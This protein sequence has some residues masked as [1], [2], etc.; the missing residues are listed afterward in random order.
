MRRSCS[1]AL[2]AVVGRAVLLAGCC[3][4]ASSARL[5]GPCE[6]ADAA[7]VE[8]PIIGATD[9][10]V[11]QLARN[12]LADLEDFW[13]EQFPDVFGEDFPPLQ[14]GYFSVDPGNVDPAAYPAASAAGPPVAG[15]REQRLL[16]HRA[17]RPELRLDQLRPRLPGRRSAHELRPVHPGA[18]DGARVR[19]RRAGAGWAAPSAVDRRRDPGRL[20]RRQPGPGGSPTGEAEHSTLRDPGA[21]R[22]AAR[23]PA[24]ARPGRH[25]RGRGAGAR[26]LLRPGRRPS[27][28]ASTAARRPAATT[29]APTGSSPQAAFDR[30]GRSTTRRQRR[31]RR[32]ARR[33]STTSLPG[34]WGQAFDELSGE[35]FDPP[36][37]RAVRRGAPRTVRRRQDLDL[38]Y[39]ADEN[40][41]GFDESDLAPAGLRGARRLRR[42]HRGR[43]ALRAGRPR[44]A[45]PVHRR[46]GG[47]PLGGLPERLVRRRSVYNGQVSEGIEHLAPATSTRACS[48]CSPYGT[49]AAVLPAADLTG[50]ELV[51]LF[52]AGFVAGSATP[53]G[54]DAAQ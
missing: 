49:R 13:A 4:E 38:V 20:L 46:R 24:A 6:P 42:R 43:A 26:L 51:D 21:R 34:A 40:L 22:V 8:V 14:G 41:V 1:R 10:E 17:R 3:P 23:V 15:R 37:D 18:G 11:D 36:V 19:P 16:L 30:R 7:D 39:C 12:A 48:S 44:P 9:E 5:A 2:P 28:R 47:G 50:F 25:Q 29:S 45:G 31:P 33:S 35:R 52:R 32:A 27:R 54:L 53:A